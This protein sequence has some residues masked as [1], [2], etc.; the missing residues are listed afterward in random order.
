MR[1]QL[2]HPRA[3]P[4]A[5]VYEVHNHYIEFLPVAVA[6]SNT[7]FDAQRVPGQV[8]VDA[9]R[10]ELEVYAFGPSLG[11]NHDLTALHE[12]FDQGRAVSVALEPVMRS[13]PSWRF[14]QSL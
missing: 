2:A 12:M 14:H 11:G 6:P 10:T 7:L 13:V 3:C 8:V 1:Q 5:V 4:I 9:E